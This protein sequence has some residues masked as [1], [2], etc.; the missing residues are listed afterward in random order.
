VVAVFDSV[1]MVPRNRSVP[2]HLS[3]NPR[4]T[5]RQAKRAHH[6]DAVLDHEAGA[7]PH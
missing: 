2:Y 7:C 1:R 3:H 4:P 6:P 5:T